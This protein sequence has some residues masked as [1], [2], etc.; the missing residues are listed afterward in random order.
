VTF[1]GLMFTP[2]FYVINRLMA[3]RATEWAG[4]IRARI[5]GNAAAA[6]ATTEA[7]E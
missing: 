7:A 5:A 2:S 3:D 6:P 4:C 1:F